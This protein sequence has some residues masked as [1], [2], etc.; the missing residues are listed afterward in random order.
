[1]SPNPLA[2]TSFG[3]TARS[4]ES[5]QSTSQNVIAANQVLRTHIEKLFRWGRLDCSL[6][7]RSTSLHKYHDHQSRPRSC[8]AIGP[9]SRRRRKRPTKRLSFSGVMDPFPRW[10]PFV[11]IDDYHTTINFALSLLLPSSPPFAPSLSPFVWSP[12]LGQLSSSSPPS[13][14]SFP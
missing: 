6:Q 13:F 4:C 5:N 7:L 3:T 8:H 12:S 11:A 2:I 14:S 9:P 10:L 1:M